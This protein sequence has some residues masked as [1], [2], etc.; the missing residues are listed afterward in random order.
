M[1][2]KKYLGAAAVGAVAAAALI[3]A[4]DQWAHASAQGAVNERPAAAPA[5]IAPTSFAD[6]VQ[7]VAPAVVSIDVEGKGGRDAVAL[8]GQPFSFNLPDGNDGDDGLGG[9]PFDFRRLF[10]QQPGGRGG[11]PDGQE[12]PRMQATG[13][14]FF[15]SAD[16]YIVTNNHVVEGADVITVRTSDDRSLKAKLIGRDPATDLAVIKVQGAAFPFVSFEDRAKPRVGD[17]VIAVGNPFNL[18]GTATAGIVS[19]LGRPN[20]SGSS[21]VDYMQID[22]PI[23]RGNSGG[24]TFDVYGRVV[25]VNSAIFSPSGGSV[26]IGFDIPADVAASVAKQLIAEGKVTRGY[27]GATVQSVTPE[28]AESLG[29]GDKKGALVAELTPGGPS[30]KAGLRPGDLVMKVNGHDVASA[31]A[32][33]REVGLARG[34]EDIRLQVRREGR[35]QDIVVRSG[36][37]P[38]EAVLA[39]TGYDV[40]PQTDASR[41]G[42]RVL[43]MSL[44]PK[45]GGGVAVE[46]VAGNSDAGRKGLRQGDVILQA[47]DQ[48]AQSPADVA[49]AVAAARKAGRPSVLL[50]VARDGRRTFV[51]V[52]VGT[53][54]G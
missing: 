25:G 41:P 10:P 4:G 8:Q 49:N 51:P 52:E 42:A 34:G 13:S 50:M 31:A 45:E 22:A 54:A 6:L 21:Y 12:L 35:V 11:Q 1:S 17:W 20:V 53:G 3:G 37:R 14:G 26:G 39:R 30:E 24:P 5:S 23:N 40:Q 27:I 19:A 38:S 9:L 32:L 2:R 43:G 46:S 28:I 7:R 29:L 44:S 47:G 16:G 18:G 48:K 15:I 33:T 36:V